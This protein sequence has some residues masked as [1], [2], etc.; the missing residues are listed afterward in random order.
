MSRRRL[1]RR[2]VEATVRDTQMAALEF[3]EARSW[4]RSALTTPM[5]PLAAEVWVFDATLTRVL[6]VHHRWRGWVPPGGKV[7]AGETPREAAARE[8]EEETGLRVKLREQPAAVAVRSFHP[9]WPATLSV[10]Y[11]AIASSHQTLK[12]E[13]GQPAAW[14]ELGR[15]WASHFSED[16]ARMRQYVDLGRPD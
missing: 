13:S 7:E 3:D 6:L 11:A 8:L 9:D 5:E 10:S 14:M 4:L 1:E 2:V 15:N 16:R 12:P